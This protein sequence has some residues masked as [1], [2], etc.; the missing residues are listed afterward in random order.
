MLQIAIKVGNSSDIVFDNRAIKAFRAVNTEQL[1]WQLEKYD[2]IRLLIIEKVA[3]NEYEEIQ[4]LIQDYLNTDDTHAIIYDKYNDSLTCNLA[5]ENRLDIAINLDAL[6]SFI[7]RTYGIHSSTN[8][9]T[10]KLSNKNENNTV[11][12]F[13]IIENEQVETEEAIKSEELL[14]SIDKTEGEVVEENI[15][16]N[17][18]IVETSEDIKSAVYIKD[19]EELNKLKEQNEQ[20]KKLLKAMQDERDTFSNILARIQK[21]SVI[22]ESNI[23]SYDYEQ[24]ETALKELEDECA[25]Q[26]L[27]IDHVQ[28]QYTLLKRVYEQAD[29][30]IMAISALFGIDEY[31]KNGYSGVVE[32]IS[33]KISE[34]NKAIADKDNEYTEL[35]SSVSS[36]KVTIEQ[37]EDNKKSA[38]V[39]IETLEKESSRLNQYIQKLNE[40]L[41]SK[42]HSINQLNTEI[43]GLTNEI[44]TIK[45]TLY[46]SKEENH[47][48]LA[49]KLEAESK[50]NSVIASNYEKQHEYDV[51]IQE[52]EQDNTSK[53][54]EIEKL[55]SEAAI[56]QAENAALNKKYADY[57]TSVSEKISGYD[58]LAEKLSIAES[59]ASDYLNTITKIKEELAAADR[60][61]CSL[62][63]RTAQY[64]ETIKKLRLQLKA[65]SDY[66]GDTS[67]EI[68]D[69]VYS[70]FGRVIP[71]LGCGSYGITMTAMSLAY[72][73][74][75]T[76]TVVYIDF[77]TAMPKADSWFKIN[78]LAKGISGITNEIKS[79]GL[80]VLIERDYETFAINAEALINNVVQT[81]KGKIDYI[82]G[83]YTKADLYKIMTANYSA[84][85]NYLGSKYDYIVLD[86]GKFGYSDATDKVIKAF[87]KV[88]YKNII[89][90]TGDK[91]EVRTFRIRLTEQ[92][93]KVS[94]AIWLLN[95]CQSTS[96]EETAKKSI[97][98]AEYVIM[99]FH[100]DLY[101]SKKD[102]TKTKITNGKFEAL[103]NKLVKAEE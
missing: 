1:K 51:K 5:Y 101:G 3:A 46:A 83:L 12:P 25:R 39:L 2:G 54:L 69:I 98:P 91:F 43:D 21:D 85:L 52:L 53:K 78:P 17:S 42:E 47:R 29:G 34:L 15:D 56:A 79:T 61:K 82:S 80:G 50:L 22:A 67:T 32:H 59:K 62:R 92:K 48:L 30:V 19:A 10:L 89:V 71:V 66:T 60:E 35:F 102:F 23:N 99:P 6:Y 11:E 81:K 24:L 31:N 94:N 57:E 16:K 72:A 37:L 76:N 7:D 55:L 70:G 103:L 8:I 58:L 93:M 33:E 68:K 77:D 14:L 63:D 9:S 65:L 44:E 97:S 75:A 40:E 74:A 13:N 18:D 88:A 64:E 100:Y 86:M 49:E 4:G 20:L 38:T 90:T 36:L 45:S 73:L 84:F 41:E 27:D 95:M 96:I 28:E 87:Y 26:K